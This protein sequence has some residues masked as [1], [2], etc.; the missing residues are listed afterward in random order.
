[1]FTTDMKEKTNKCVD[2]DD[3]DADTVR[4]MLLFMYTD[5]LDDLQYESAK[6]LYFAAVKYNIVSLKH[7]CSNFLKQNI[8]LTNC[9][10]ILFLADK[11]QDEDLKNAEN[12]EAVLFSDQW[13]NVEKNHPQLTL[14]VF[15]A[16]YMKN[17]RSK[18]HTQS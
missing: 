9:C 1:M 13:K 10:D 17:R 7:R 16:V 6:N 11:N 4:R 5:T 12:D 15:R 14:E 2:I 8:L 3:L 18:E